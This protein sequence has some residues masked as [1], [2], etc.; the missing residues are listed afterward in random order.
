MDDWFYRTRSYVGDRD[1]SKI[2]EPD[3]NRARTSTGGSVG[4]S[5][6]YRSFFREG[7]PFAYLYKSRY[8][9][10]VTYLVNLIFVA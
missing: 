2:I 5:S 4:V 8:P 1:P 6:F 9:S 10:V 7:V 3:R